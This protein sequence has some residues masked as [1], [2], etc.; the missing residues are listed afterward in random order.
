MYLTLGENL[1]QYMS[2]TVTFAIR[3]GRVGTPGFLDDLRQAIWSVDPGVPL[4]SVETLGDLHA[5]ATARAAL[6]LV[7]V[8]IATLVLVAIAAVAAY[9][10]ARR[11]GGMDPAAALR[12]E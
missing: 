11:V 3:S 9:L 5:R 4:V 12:A 8:A 7:L 10:P 2:R 6:I 1:A